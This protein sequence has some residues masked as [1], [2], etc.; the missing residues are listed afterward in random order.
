MTAEF[1][2][3]AGRTQ[4]IASRGRY[5]PNVQV[6]YYGNFEIG[7]FL[8][9]YGSICNHGYG[10]YSREHHFWE[11]ECSSSIYSSNEKKAMRLA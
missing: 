8:V 4:C 1:I 9:G 7:S 3:F 5:G 10:F 6:Q 11:E 2:D